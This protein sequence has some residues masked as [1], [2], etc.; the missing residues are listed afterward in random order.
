MGSLIK[1]TST[2]NLLRPASRECISGV[3]TSQIL[4]V[5]V[6]GFCQVNV[7]IFDIP[8][9][10]LNQVSKQAKGR[11]MLYTRF[12]IYFFDKEDTF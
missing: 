9:S 3:I 12:V 8:R 5:T 4:R 11:K 1:G 10:T 6:R 2:K 7:K